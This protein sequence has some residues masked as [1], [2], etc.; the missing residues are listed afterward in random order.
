MS[1]IKSVI[2]KI[3]LYYWRWQLK[4][5]GRDT[6]IDLGVN[7]YNPQNISLGDQVTINTGAKLQSCDAATITLGKR[8]T[9]S[10]NAL[11]LTGGLDLNSTARDVSRV[12]R[13]HIT[14][15]VIIEDNVWI[16]AGAIILPGVTVR[17]GSVVAAGSV[18]TKDVEASSLV[19]GVPATVVKQVDS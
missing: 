1:K 5:C 3:F 8:V 17:I 16:G 18:V 4:S 2:R 10:Y 19:A 9:V 12:H 6:V 11:I 14:A 7:I 13:K 15:D